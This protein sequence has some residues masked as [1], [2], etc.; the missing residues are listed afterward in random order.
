MAIKGNKGEWS[1]F[2]AFIKILTDGKMFAAD[3]DL[4]ILKDKFFTVLQI[5]RNE[6]QGK[7]VYDISKSPDNIIIT[8]ENGE[9][10][11]NR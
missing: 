10:S 2:Y 9:K 11:R 5:I 7:K 6:K 4:N 1:E 3:K 8:N